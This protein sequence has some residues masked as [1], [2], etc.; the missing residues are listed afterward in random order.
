GGRIRDFL[1]IHYEILSTSLLCLF[2]FGNFPMQCTDF[3][4]R[5]L[6]FSSPCLLLFHQFYHLTLAF[7]HFLSQF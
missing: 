1:L 6:L 4:R 3:I 7:H 2:I 5:F